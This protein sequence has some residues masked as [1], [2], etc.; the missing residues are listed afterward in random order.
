M[1][2]YTFRIGDKGQEVKKLQ[3]ALENLVAD[4]DFGPA[5]EKAVKEYQ[6]S[7]SLASDGI[8][9][10]ATL[11]SL[12]IP[13]EIGVDLSRWNGNV[14]FESMASAGI[15]YAWVKCSEGTTHIN[16]G[17]EKKF[18]D[19][20]DA[21]IKVGGYHFSRPDTHPSLQDAVDESLNFLGALSKVGFYSGDLL[22]VLDVEAGVKTDDKYNT[23]WILKWLS[24]VEKS[25]GVKPVIY[26]GRWAYNLYLR[27]G[28]PDHL[29]ELSTYP[30]WIASYNDGIQPKR[31]ADLWDE[32]TV[33]QWTGSGIVPG[34]KGKCDIN[35]CAGGL[36]PSLTHR[37][38]NID[39][40]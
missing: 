22:P 26:T 19:A 16:P 27:D 20:R 1:K 14:D 25:L 34:V 8:A 11:G 24:S 7:N 5:T 15:K 40:S 9:G 23:E 38:E 18:K 36:L 39:C 21:G 4:G 35:W 29:K 3:Y 17:Y 6:S 33:W 30:L 37:V 32:W 28:D 10:P 12:G 13:V 2:T 31:M